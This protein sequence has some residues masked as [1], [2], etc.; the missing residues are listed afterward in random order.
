MRLGW[1]EVWKVCRG[2]RKV[3]ASVLGSEGRHGQKFGWC[4]GVR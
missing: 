2:V 4:G 3:R 1:G